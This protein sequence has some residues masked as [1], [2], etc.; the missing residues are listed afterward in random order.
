MRRKIAA[1]NWKMNGLSAD[2][3]ELETLAPLLSADGPDVIIC[4]PAPLL[5]R[6]N[7][8]TK[9][10]GIRIG[11]QDCHTKESG[12]FTGD[13]AAKMIA[14]TGASYVIVGHS[15]RRAE[16]SES[17]SDVRSKAETAWAAG[18]T[19]IICIGESLEDH[20]SGKT[21]EIIAGQL[22]NSLPDTMTADNTII[23]YEPIWAIGTG[24]VPTFEQ[25][26]EVHDF[27]RSTL[28]AR[29]GADIA[30]HIPL[31][32]GGSVKPD[33]AAKIFEA[34]NVDGALVG[35]ASLKAADFAPI[36]TALAQ[37]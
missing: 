29:Y 25:I 6:A 2:L 23:A 1:G 12:A 11:A 32:Y 5:D 16:H 33:N 35:G 20:A 30:D 31:L 18:L 17:D 36:I 10:S 14:D 4:P 26:S 15:E 9:G 19:A 24:H 37:S 27:I 21:L 28:T 22:A 8:A 34:E 7:T 3:I 13:L